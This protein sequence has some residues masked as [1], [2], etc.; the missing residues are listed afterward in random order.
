MFTQLGALMSLNETPSGNL[1]CHKFCVKKLLLALL[2][3]IFFTVVITTVSR[4]NALIWVK[5]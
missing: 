3:L 2:V 5:F 1:M 4:R